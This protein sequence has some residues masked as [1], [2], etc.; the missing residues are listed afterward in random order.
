MPICSTMW[1]VSSA[2]ANTAPPTL[3][4]NTLRLK[5]RM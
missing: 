1:C 3:M 4:T 2:S 5:M